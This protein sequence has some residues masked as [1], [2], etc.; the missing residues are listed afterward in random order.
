M[1][2]LSSAV[3]DGSGPRA[4]G[5]GPTNSDGGG[6]GGS[7]LAIADETS[8]PGGAVADEGPIRPSDGQRCSPHYGDRARH[9]L[10]PR[11]RGRHRI[12]SVASVEGHSHPR[13]LRRLGA[14][15]HADRRHALVRPPRRRGTGA[16]QVR[17]GTAGCARPAQ[18]PSPR[19]SRAGQRI[20]GRPS[21]RVEA[22]RTQ[23][24]SAGE[25]QAPG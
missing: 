25:M 19:C 21:L 2:L 6:L 17:T 12:H 1:C 15:A 10:T 24:R 20:V 3:T 14:P 4:L 16:G 13:R 23:A 22:R 5:I 18:M 9:I 11:S 7:H 8:T